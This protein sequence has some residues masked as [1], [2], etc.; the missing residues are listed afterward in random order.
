MLS[1]EA[2][3]ALFDTFYDLYNTEDSWR[4]QQSKAYLIKTITNNYPI[5][6]L[7]S[8]LIINKWDSLINSDVWEVAKTAAIKFASYIEKNLTK[9]NS[10]SK[11]NCSKFI[12][13]F[14]DSKNYKKRMLYLYM[15]TPLM[16]VFPE[17]YWTDIANLSYDKVANV[18]I[19][20]AKI[21]K[22]QGDIISDIP[23][24]EEAEANLQDSGIKEI[25]AIYN[26]NERHKQTI[27]PINYDWIFLKFI[28][29]QDPL[30]YFYATNK[31]DLNDPELMVDKSEDKFLDS[32]ESKTLT[33]NKLSHII[34]K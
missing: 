13:K 16:K 23:E 31:V 22:S 18:K 7:T 33:S 19:L 2:K 8:K 1:A 24:L 29:D 25:D 4:V 11:Q 20:L 6:K 9:G 26:E 14:R 10:V 30:S 28:D 17:L 32:G 5:E 12:N 27:I 21:L 34:K 3:D 15:V